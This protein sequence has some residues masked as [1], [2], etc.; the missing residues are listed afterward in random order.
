MVGV[1]AEVGMA[2]G[3][4]VAAGAEV[5]PSSPQATISKTQKSTEKSGSSRRFP[6]S[7]CKIESILTFNLQ[8]SSQIYP[9]CT[10]AH[11]AHSMHT[12]TP[13][14]NFACETHTRRK[15]VSS[16]EKEAQSLRRDKPKG[17]KCQQ[18]HQTTHLPGGPHPQ[19]PETPNHP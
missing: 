12:H 2:V 13:N 9:E 15:I 8:T 4:T 19:P 18:A 11:S 14:S 3:A 17:I 10:N 6:A 5:D 1:G 16:Q 7:A